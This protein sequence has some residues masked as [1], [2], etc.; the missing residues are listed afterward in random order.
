MLDLGVEDQPWTHQP[1]LAS[2]SATGLRVL[3]A[4]SARLTLMRSCKSSAAPAAELCSSTVSD[5][6]LPPL[7]SACPPSSFHVRIVLSAIVGWRIARLK[8]LPVA[9]RWACMLLLQVAL[10]YALYW[11][12][13][14]L[15]GPSDQA[16]LW[17]PVAI[18]PWSG[19]GY[20]DWLPGV[21]R[22]RTTAD[23]V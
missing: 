3:I 14:W 7:L 13:F 23:I 21:V 6:Q 8:R 10:A 20:S 17:A 11:A 4:G 2:G 22:L 5:A 15:R 12:P 16:A 1:P 9:V 18:V 19:R